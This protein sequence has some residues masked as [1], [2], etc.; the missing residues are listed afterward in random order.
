MVVGQA[1]R[2]NDYFATEAGEVQG[3]V[4]RR[5]QYR[6]GEGE[7]VFELSADHIP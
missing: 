3:F 6:L 1:W 2:D 4:H 5:M 7:S